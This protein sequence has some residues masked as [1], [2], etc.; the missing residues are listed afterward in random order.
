MSATSPHF[1]RGQLVAWLNFLGERGNAEDFSEAAEEHVK[2][3]YDQDRLRTGKSWSRLT[4]DYYQGI[5]PHA[6]ADLLFFDGFDRSAA[7]PVTPATKPRGGYFHQQD[8]V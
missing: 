7:A 2:I 5:L 8:E 1:S 6:W 4:I 3:F